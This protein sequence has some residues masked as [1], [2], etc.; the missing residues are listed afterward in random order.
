MVGLSAVI[1]VPDDTSRTG[2]ARPML[3]Q[4]LMGTPLLAWLVDSLSAGGVE[5]F[6]LVCAPG[7]RDDARACFPADRQPVF[8]EKEADTSRELQEFLTSVDPKNE[9]V[10][11]VTGPCVVLPFASEE[12]AFDGPPEQANMLCIGRTALLGA[13]RQN[14]PF[15]P[16]LMEYGS[17]YSDRDGV[18]SVLS[19][20]ELADWQPVLNHMRL[21]RLIQ[22]G[23]EV[24]DYNGIFVDPRASVAPGAVLL[25]GTVIRG[26]SVIGAGTSVGPNAFVED[27]VIGADCAVGTAQVLRAQVGDQCRIGSY[28]SLLPGTVLGNRVTVGTCAELRDVTVGDGAVLCHGTYAADGVIG[29]G[30]RMDPGAATVNSDPDGRYRTVIEEQAY[31]GSGVRLV[32]PVHVGSG[33]YAAAGSVIAED[34]PAQAMA[35]ARARQTGKKDWA[36]KL[37]GKK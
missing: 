10:I 18:Y 1:F 8:A 22:A 19:M 16:F 14:R 37:S 21:Y 32:A 11:V 20:N 35:I 23:V 36:G 27:A 26:N 5:R 31:I 9:D 6:F 3:L 25:P 12:A 7:D 33:A 4:N 34:I 29:A 24:W 17:H 15:L 30:V 13:L 28:A 2:C